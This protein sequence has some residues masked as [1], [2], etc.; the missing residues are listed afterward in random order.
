[1]SRLKKRL[2]LTAALLVVGGAAVGIAYAAIPNGGVITGCY[3][4]GGGSLDVI[5]ATATNCKKNETR[6]D[7]NVQGPKGDPGTNGEDG[8]SGYEIVAHTES[9]AQ[10]SLFLTGTVSALCPAGKR[11]LGGGATVTQTNTGD[12]NSGGTVQQSAPNSDGTRWA[13]YLD[14]D[15]PS[16][17]PFTVKVYAICANVTS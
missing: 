3:N 2:L 14:I 10:G 7:W 13:V 15:N 12:V 4:T 6:L 5:D 9:F 16:G 11:V 8:V 17:D 1:M